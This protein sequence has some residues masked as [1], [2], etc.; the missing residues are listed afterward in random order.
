MRLHRH[1]LIV[2]DGRERLLEDPRH[3][4]KE[5]EVREAVTRRYEP[6]L[7]TAGLLGSLILH[8]KM[9]REVRQEVE[10]LAPRDALYLQARRS[11]RRRYR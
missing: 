1:N 6:E 4:P 8:A 11:S 10:A 2:T 9:R 3:G 7:A 5:R